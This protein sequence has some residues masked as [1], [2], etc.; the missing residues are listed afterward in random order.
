[1]ALMRAPQCTGSLPDGLSLSN[2]GELSGTP[3]T[4]GTANFIVTATNSDECVGD[5]TYSLTIA[6]SSANGD[7]DG[8]GTTNG[9]DISHFVECVI[10][11]STSGGSCGPGDFNNSGGVDANDVAQF[12]AALLAA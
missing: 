9:L 6:G 3:T 12:I 10:S 4:P 11:G 1:M 8:S 5:Q 7:L 2:A